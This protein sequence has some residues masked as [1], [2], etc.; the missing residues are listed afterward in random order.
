MKGNVMDCLVSSSIY[1]LKHPNN[2]SSS[3]R[4]WGSIAINIQSNR[5]Y[6]FDVLSQQYHSNKS[7][8]LFD[9]CFGAG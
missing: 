2:L 4:A 3:I 5:V 6:A 9:Y 7:K 1:I 8:P